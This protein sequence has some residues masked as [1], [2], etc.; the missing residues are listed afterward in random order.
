MATKKNTTPQPISAADLRKKLSTLGESA[1]AILNNVMT[2]PAVDAKQ[3][4]DVAKFIITQVLDDPSVLNNNG[5]NL[6]KLAE[7]LKK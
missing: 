4:V 3:K 5:D 2:D 6:L 1:I 7:I